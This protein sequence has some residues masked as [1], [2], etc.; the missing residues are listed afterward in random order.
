MISP[1]FLWGFKRTTEQKWNREPVDPTVYGFQF[2]RGTRWNP[3]LSNLEI[4]EYENALGMRF[5]HDVRAFLSVMNGTDMPTLNV[6]AHCGEPHR[7]SVGVYSH[8]RD[9]KIIK[10][11]IRDVHES[12]DEIARDLKEQGFDLPNEADLLPIYGHRYVVCSSDLDS[13]VVLSIVVHDVD[14]IVYGNS[15]REYLERDFLGRRGSILA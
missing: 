15:L 14:A 7:T 6:Y 8:P 11:R 5:P 2:Q 3:G 1:D 13:S 9:L 4:R 10:E 12:R